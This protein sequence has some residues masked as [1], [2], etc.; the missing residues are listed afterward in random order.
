MRFQGSG[1]AVTL[2]ATP[3][4]EAPTADSQILFLFGGSDTNTV[5]LTKYA[6]NGVKLNNGAS[7]TFGLDD[8]MIFVARNSVWV[9]ISRTNV[10]V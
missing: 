9:E 7:F 8:N 5:T 10:T 2:T 4:I 1:G 3:A 6:N